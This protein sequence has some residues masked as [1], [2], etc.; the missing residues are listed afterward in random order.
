MGRSPRSVDRAL[1][2][3]IAGLEEGDAEACRRIVLE[4]YLSG[5]SVVRVCDAL[6]AQA[7]HAVGS[8]WECGRLEIY[9][10]HRA[11]EILHGTL[12]ELRSLLPPP[13]PNAPTA[14]GGTPPGDNYRLPS[15]AVELVLIEA[16]WRTVSLGCSLPFITMA[17]AAQSHQPDLFWLSLSHVGAMKNLPGD[18]A[19]FLEA[20][21]EQTRVVIGGQQ[22]EAASIADDPRIVRCGDLAEL[23]AFLNDFRPT[24]ERD[25]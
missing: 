23:N 17:A 9:Q 24:I 12:Y 22:L 8:G 6:I 7:M 15:L 2:G 13:D 3:L 10:E 20:L 4:V 19:D 25:G 14:V 5:T 11:S 1:E 21:P 18:F 16:G